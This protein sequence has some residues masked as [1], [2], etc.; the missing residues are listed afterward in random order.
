V[1]TPTG[2]DAFFLTAGSGEE[3][4]VRHSMAA[5]RGTLGVCPQ[6][7]LLAWQPAALQV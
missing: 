5:I 7:R 3:L 1:L 6:V 4:S 2:G